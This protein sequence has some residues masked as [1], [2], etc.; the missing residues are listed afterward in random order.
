MT[1][2][3]LMSASTNLHKESLAGGQS[4]RPASRGQRV[5]RSGSVMTSYWSVCP[6]RDTC[7]SAAVLK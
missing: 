3:P 2:W 7:T 1:N 5:R 6:V 4:T